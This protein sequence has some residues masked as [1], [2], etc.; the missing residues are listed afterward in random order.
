[1]SDA[2]ER[3]Q[4]HLLSVRVY[5]RLGPAT[6][7]GL[8]KALKCGIAA[9]DCLRA[10]DKPDLVFC[11]TCEQQVACCICPA[12][13]CMLTTRHDEARERFEEVING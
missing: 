11:K 4:E 2:I 3:A 1:M 12:S 7:E 13:D 5:A 10:L 8:R 6:R 9:L